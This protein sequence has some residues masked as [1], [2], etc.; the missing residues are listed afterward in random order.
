[1]AREHW[2]ELGFPS[3]VLQRD[4]R[5][6]STPSDVWWSGDAGQVGQYLWGY[7]SLW[8]PSSLLASASQARLADALFAG[9]RHAGIGL[10]FNKGLA[11]APGEAIA[12]AKDTAMNPA[13]LTAFALAI[14]ADGQGSAYPGI[15]GHEPDI[16]KAR[17]SAKAIDECVEQLRAVAGRS[18]SYVNETNYFEKDWQRAFWGDNYP[19]L[20]EIKKKY[21]PSGLFFVHNGVGSEAWS[22]DVSRDC[23]RRH[24][25]FADW[26]RPGG[27]LWRRLGE[28]SD[29]RKWPVSARRRSCCEG[30][31]RLFS[32]LV[33]A[34]AVVVSCARSAEFAPEVG[35]TPSRREWRSWIVDRCSEHRLQAVPYALQ[36]VDRV[37]ADLGRQQML[38]RRGSG[39]CPS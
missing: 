33:V 7:E 4:G 30:I 8:L 35:Q 38:L 31:S 10:H 3:P 34:S 17:A 5:P 23:E 24:S 6:G 9:S 26:V 27:P 28:D 29:D 15:P 1:L 37:P 16:T 22:R 19:R 20:A 2:Q 13:V 36:G 21:D 12:A 25:V 14:V 32:G 39:R 11:G 18:G